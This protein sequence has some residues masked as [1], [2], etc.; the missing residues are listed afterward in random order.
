M[1]TLC[2]KEGLTCDSYAWLVTRLDMYADDGNE[3]EGRHLVSLDVYE[4]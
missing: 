1:Q 2:E 4:G 3:K